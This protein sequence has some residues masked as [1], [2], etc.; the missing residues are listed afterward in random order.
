MRARVALFARRIWRCIVTD[1]HRSIVLTLLLIASACAFIPFTADMPWSWLDNA[2]ALG[3]N[4]AVAQGLTFGRDIIFTFGPYSC[5]FSRVYHPATNAKLLVGSGLLSLACWY[6]IVQLTRDCKRYALWALWIVLVGLMYSRDALLLSYPFLAGLV[7]CQSQ[8]R[9]S[10]LSR[11]AAR[12]EVAFLFSAFGLLPLIKGSILVLC[13]LIGLVAIVLFGQRRRWDLAIA[14]VAGPALAMSA[15]WM[16]AGQPV[17]AMPRYLASMLPLIFGYA[18]AMAFPGNPSEIIWYLVG[19]AA[20]IAAVVWQR[21]RADRSRAAVGCVLGAFLFVA[22]KAGF[23]RH[24]AHAL[25]CRP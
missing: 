17:L 7:C 1:L 25:A 19:A 2:W 6:A 22:F 15:F 16:F 5:I 8:A 10:E 9:W 18:D 20:L 4:Q 24:D 21:P 23:V 14:A 12:A 13:G 11:N 3:L